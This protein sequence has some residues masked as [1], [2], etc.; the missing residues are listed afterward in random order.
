V[1]ANQVIVGKNDQLFHQ[2]LVL[3]DVCWSIPTPT[4]WQGRVQIRSRH[5]AAKAALQ[6]LENDRFLVRFS[7]PQR[8]ITPGQF[9]VFY[10]D[11]QVIGSG[12]IVGASHNMVQI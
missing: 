8:A 10:Q 3:R 9:A 7:K 1:A 5:R 6:P 12:I 11:E 2:D 4:K